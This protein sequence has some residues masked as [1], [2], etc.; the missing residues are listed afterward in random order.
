MGINN[1]K[2]LVSA[3]KTVA[4][5]AATKKLVEATIEQAEHAMQSLTLEE[6]FPYMTSNVKVWVRNA[7]S[8]PEEEAMSRIG[9]VVHSGLQRWEATT[10]TE[11]GKVLQTM[12]QPIDALKASLPELEKQ[13][14]DLQNLVKQAAFFCPP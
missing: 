3:A 14:I 4:E 11:L 2:K 7:K 8:L 5:G 1:F 13:A 10:K 6:L 9:R 12:R